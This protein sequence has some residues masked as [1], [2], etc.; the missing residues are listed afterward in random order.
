MKLLLE[1][2]EKLNNDNVID[3]KCVN[4]DEKNIEQD[5]E[6]PEEKQTDSFHG[7]KRSKASKIDT[8]WLILIN[9]KEF[10]IDCVLTPGLF[11]N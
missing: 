3:A 4:D 7:T 11:Y 9:D 6:K 1:E 5:D 8:Q 2:D 10:I